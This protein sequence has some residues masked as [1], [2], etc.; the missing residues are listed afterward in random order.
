MTNGKNLCSQ[1][2][3]CKKLYKV[4]NGSLEIAPTVTTDHIEDTLGRHLPRKQVEKVR[5]LSANRWC[6]VTDDSTIIE[7]KNAGES[8]MVLVVVNFDIDNGPGD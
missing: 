3:G 6:S 4:P 2:S 7:T 5:S 8:T 1:V